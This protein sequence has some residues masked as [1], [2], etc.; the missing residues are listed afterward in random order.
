MSNQ[1]HSWAN[2]GNPISEGMYLSENDYKVDPY[3]KAADE[4]HAMNQWNTPVGREHPDPLTVL[5]QHWLQFDNE[6]VPITERM[7]VGSHMLEVWQ[8]EKHTLDT[9]YQKIGD[10][11]ADIVKE[12]LQ[13]ERPATGSKN[14]RNFRLCIALTMA[15]ALFFP[16][17]TVA[18]FLVIRNDSDDEFLEVKIG[19]DEY[20]ICYCDK[21]DCMCVPF[22]PHPFLEDS[23]SFLRCS[24]DFASLLNVTSC[25]ENSC[26]IQG[27]P[28]CET[29]LRQSLTTARLT[30]IQSSDLAKT[31][32]GFFVSR[33]EERCSQVWDTFTQFAEGPVTGNWTQPSA[34]QQFIN[35]FCLAQLSG[36]NRFGQLDCERTLYLWLT[37]LENQQDNGFK[38][39]S[40]YCDKYS[41]SL[42]SSYECPR[43]EDLAPMYP[44]P[45]LYDMPF[46]ASVFGLYQGSL[47]AAEVQTAFGTIFNT[48]LANLVNLTIENLAVSLP[49]AAAAREKV[50]QRNL[51]TMKASVTGY[52]VS[53]FGIGGIV[54]FFVI[55]FIYLLTANPCG[56]MRGGMLLTMKHVMACL[57]VGDAVFEG[58]TDLV[59]DWITVFTDV[60]KRQMSQETWVQLFIGATMAN[61]LLHFVH[62]ILVYFTVRAEL[63]YGR[64]LHLLGGIRLCLFGTDILQAV[65]LI[66]L[67]WWEELGEAGMIY[68]DLAVKSMALVSASF[69]AM[70]QFWFRGKLRFVA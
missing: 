31:S 12:K 23:G 54:F 30:S 21:C 48:D 28:G 3:G 42:N 46:L 6:D 27:D 25:V 55:G 37:E 14:W 17:A 34:W 19:E 39:C 10:A 58:G 4:L 44:E 40:L 49:R 51:C 47:L 41:W 7:G 38:A 70:G 43:I 60:W 56:S 59:V 13:T 52:V 32:C 63:L 53:L 67:V 62:W 36:T 68:A 22:E 20:H 8:M 61:S 65:L 57:E 1:T 45:W 29:C 26:E 18:T 11:L 16:V 33:W 9:A 2:G 50:S 35:G 24:T 64:N 5:M 66:G 15:I 69:P